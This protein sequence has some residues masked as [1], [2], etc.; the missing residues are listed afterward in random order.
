MDIAY[1]MAMTLIASNVDL[2]LNLGILNVVSILSIKGMCV[3]TL[4]LVVMTN[5]GSTFQPLLTTLSIGGL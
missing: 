5:S 4:A 3:A 2:M 1:C